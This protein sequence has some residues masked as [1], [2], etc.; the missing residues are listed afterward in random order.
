[1]SRIAEQKE[2]LFGYKKMKRSMG[3]RYVSKLV[4]LGS[5]EGQKCDDDDDENKDDQTNP[6]ERVSE[7]E[8]W[9]SFND[10]EPADNDSVE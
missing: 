8:L 9:R 2:L 3:G 5:C 10:N 7:V 1:M 6:E 4:G